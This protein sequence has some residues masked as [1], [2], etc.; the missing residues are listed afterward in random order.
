MMKYIPTS[1]I[2]N[3]LPIGIYENSDI[4]LM[5]KSLLPKD[6]K[7]DITIDDIRQIKFNYY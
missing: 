5:L 1:T 7:L 4:N 3:T 6:V 2:E